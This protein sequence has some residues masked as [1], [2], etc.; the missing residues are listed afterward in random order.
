MSTPD[1]FVHHRLPTG[2]GAM[3][4]PVANIKVARFD[5]Q[6]L[7]YAGAVETGFSER[8]A[9]ALRERL[10]RIRAERCAA[11]GL[12]FV[13]LAG[14]IRTEISGIQRPRSGERLTP[15][16]RSGDKLCRTKR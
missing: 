6:R 1:T 12:S 7:L 14:W 15:N 4:A 11:G 3:R 13:R 9:A 5:G 16:T 2:F 8:V 10:D